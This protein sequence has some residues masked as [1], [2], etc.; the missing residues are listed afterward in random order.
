[1]N[2]P[3][4]LLLAATLNVAMTM[5]R[6]QT[7]QPAPEGRAA[8]RLS[9]RQAERVSQQQR[10]IACNRRGREAGLKSAQR[11]EF[12]RECVKGGNAA[13]GGGRPQ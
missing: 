10:L 6:G 1:M 5:A 11:K 3:A 13:V 4:R 7:A 8:P 9:E 12:I 2:R